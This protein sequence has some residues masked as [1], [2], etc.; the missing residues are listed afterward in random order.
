MGSALILSLLTFALSY[1]IIFKDDFKKEDIDKVV[2]V[3][4]IIFLIILIVS[5]LNTF[6]KG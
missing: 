5:I 3:L 1:A 2:P 6:T 4:S